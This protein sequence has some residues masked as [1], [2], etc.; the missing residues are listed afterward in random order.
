[1]RTL[2]VLSIYKLFKENN[3]KT[4]LIQKFSLFYT[5][6]YSPNTIRPFIQYSFP[7]SVKR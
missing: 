4:T 6:H 3:I 5:Y 1:M 7:P 2:D